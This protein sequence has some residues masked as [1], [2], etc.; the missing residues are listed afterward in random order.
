MPRYLV[1]DGFC[2]GGSIGDVYPDDVVD[3]TEKEARP[4]LAIGRLRL[5]PP[6]PAAAVDPATPSGAPAVPAAGSA[7]TPTE[8]AA[9]GDPAAPAAGSA[10]PPSPANEPASPPPA[11]GRK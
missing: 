2:L 5:A 10:G 1:L 4:N 7:A 3:L 8:P 6:A 9:S 11:R